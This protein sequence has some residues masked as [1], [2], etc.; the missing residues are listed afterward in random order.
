MAISLNLGQAHAR[1][2][3]VLQGV[4]IG[5]GQFKVELSDMLF[6]VINLI[7]RVFLY[8]VDK[9]SMITGC[10]LCGFVIPERGWGRGWGGPYKHPYNKFR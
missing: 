8:K 2:Q 9:V 4:G 1:T 10:L 6:S 5:P 7:F 3:K